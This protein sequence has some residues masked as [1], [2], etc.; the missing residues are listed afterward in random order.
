[1]LV[2]KQA[3]CLHWR[4]GRGRG[5]RRRR[6][7]RR[8]RGRERGMGRGKGRGG[9]RRHLECCAP[10]ELL[11]I[12]LVDLEVVPLLSHSGRP[13]DH[14]TDCPGVPEG[15]QVPEGDTSGGAGTQTGTCK[16]PHPPSRS[17]P[18]LPPHPL[19]AQLSPHSCRKEEEGRFKGFLRQP[20]FPFLLAASL[21][22]TWSQRAVSCP[23]SRTP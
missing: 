6:R 14:L 17:K 15:L 2:L 18:P 23:S 13:E 5:R 22:S 20:K 1:M 19:P 11:P 10:H 12:Y 7:R 9:R 21:S 8:R 4:R 16:P 3:T